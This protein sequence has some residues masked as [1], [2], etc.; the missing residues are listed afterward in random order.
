VAVESS[1]LIVADGGACREIAINEIAINEIAINGAFQASDCA[2]RTT[3][4]SP[5]RAASVSE[6]V[7]GQGNHRSLTVAARRN[8]A[9]ACATHRFSAL[10]GVSSAGLQSL[11]YGTRVAVG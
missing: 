3:R 5:G 6:S 8:R 7:A 4:R 1:D 10:D 9:D 11:V 2:R